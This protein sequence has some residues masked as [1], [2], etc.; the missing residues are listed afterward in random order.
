VTFTGG[1][2]LPVWQG[3]RPQAEDAHGI[4]VLCFNY[5]TREAPCSP[6][7]SHG[8]LSF[9]RAMKFDYR[10]CIAEVAA[11]GRRSALD[12]QTT[13]RMSIYGRRCQKLL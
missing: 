11:G 2:S 12:R 10:R 5:E 1:I 13:S 9:D 4:Q 8:P 7:A 3:E 6:E